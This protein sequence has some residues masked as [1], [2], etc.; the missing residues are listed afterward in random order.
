MR[1]SR[2]SVYQH[3]CG[4]ICLSLPCGWP[5]E[6]LFDR[7]A[8]HICCSLPLLSLCAFH[9]IDIR[10]GLQRQVFF[11]FFF[12]C[13]YPLLHVPFSCTD[14][15]ESHMSPLCS[16]PSWYLRR[17]HWLLLLLSC[18][19]FPINSSTTTSSARHLLFL[20]LCCQSHRWRFH[21]RLHHHGAKKCIQT[22]TPTCK[23]NIGMSDCLSTIGYHKSPTSY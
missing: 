11:F 22:C 15:T 1:F 7:I 13:M 12:F 16:V 10:N 19:F 21:H 5:W 9:R 14:S 6:A 2:S 17:W 20:P 23:A 3:F 4:E 8:G 18:L